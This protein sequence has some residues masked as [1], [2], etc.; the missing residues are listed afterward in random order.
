[1]KTHFRLLPLLCALLLAANARATVTIDFQLATALDSTSAPVAANTIGILVADNYGTGLPTAA[2]LLGAVLSNGSLIGD[3]TILRVFQAA[4]LGV[5]QFGFAD[6]LTLALGSGITGGAGT[7]GTDLGF[8]W[9]PGITTIGA[10]V[11]GGQSYGFYRSDTV[12][13]G[14]GSTMS[15]NVPSDPSSSSLY[16]LTPDLMGSTPSTSLVANLTVASAAPE[17]SRLM[18]GV[19]G[20][21]AFLMRRRRV[22]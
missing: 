8:Y 22:A 6:S 15:Y 11:S 14:D 20:L 5:N 16:T 13:T 21:G 2:E 7:A 3:S 12:A 19:M 1:M 18:L 9:F 10:T 4:D 17:P